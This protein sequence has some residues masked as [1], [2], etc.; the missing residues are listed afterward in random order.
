MGNKVSGNKVSGN[1]LSGDY[2]S[3]KHPDVEFIKKNHKPLNEIL[4]CEYNYEINNSEIKYKLFYR[5]KII[6]LTI[7]FIKS[8]EIIVLNKMVAKISVGQGKYKLINFELQSDNNHNSLCMYFYNDISLFFLFNFNT[9][10]DND[11]PDSPGGPDDNINNGHDDGHNNG[12][13]DGH[14]HIK[15]DK[16]GEIPQETTSLGEIL[17]NNKPSKTTTFK[18]LWKIIFEKIDEY[19]S[20]HY[21]PIT[22]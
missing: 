19:Y 1:K 22:C 10:G 18:G 12:H 6:S 14:D 9:N 13:D 5:A 20:A 3:V 11:G 2:A 16:S 21:T 7:P 8:D 17:D 15:F 4:G